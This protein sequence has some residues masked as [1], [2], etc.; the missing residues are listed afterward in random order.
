MGMDN[1]ILVIFNE[2]QKM[3]SNNEQVEDAGEKK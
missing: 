1:G 2:K 3:I